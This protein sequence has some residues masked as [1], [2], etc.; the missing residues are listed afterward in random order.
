MHDAT[1]G[2]SSSA[3]EILYCE[4]LRR[5]EVCESL[6]LD[7]F[8]AESP[9]HAEHAAEIR[10]LDDD[11]SNFERFGAA[12]A[13][14]ESGPT[15]GSVAPT[16]D[17]DALP[18]TRGTSAAAEKAFT[19]FLIE[20]ERDPQASFDALCRARPEIASELRA[21][22][23]D[24]RVI[25]ERLSEVSPGLGSLT[26]SLLLESPKGQD[27]AGAARAIFAGFLV[28]LRRGNSKTI[29]ELCE[30]HPEHA[31]D[32][33]ILNEH[34]FQVE[35]LFDDLAAPNSIDTMLFVRNA[36]EALSLT[37]LDESQ[38]ERLIERLLARRRGGRP[39][40]ELGEVGS[41]GMGSI[42]K[43]WDPDLRRNLAMKVAH[44]TPAEIENPD[45]PKT[46]D[47][48]LA[49]F[50]EE[51]QVTSQLDH[52][53]IVPV[54]ELGIDDAGRPYFTMRL[55]RGKDLSAI[56]E[57]VWN[58]QDGWNRTRAVGAMLK[59]CDAVAYAHSKNVVHRDLKPANVM[60]GRFGEVYVMD[61]GLARVQG[62]KSEQDER[63]RD[64]F[65]SMSQAPSLVETDRQAG[66]TGPAAESLLTAH[67]DIVGTPPYMSPE[68]ADGR[69]DDIAE[70]TDVYALGA[71]LYNLLSQ[72]TP[73]IERD[74]R[75][76]A[77]VVWK[78][79]KAGPPVPLE[80]I[81][82]QLPPELV[83]ICEKAMARTVTSRY[84]DTRMLAEDLRA[85]LED[86]VVKAYESGPVAELRKWMKRNRKAASVAGSTLFMTLGGLA[87]SAVL[88]KAGEVQAKQDAE[89]AV[90]EKDDAFAE[91]DA[92]ELAA[93]EAEDQR[94]AALD[95]RKQIEVQIV[96]LGEERDQ[97]KTE[98]RGLGQDVRV[99]NERAEDAMSRTEKVMRLSASRR[100]GQLLAESD[101]LWPPYPWMIEPMERWLEE[102]RSLGIGRAQLV[103][104]RDAMRASA[105]IIEGKELARRRSEL[106]ESERAHAL[107]NEIRMRQ[108]ALT[109]MQADSG[110]LQAILAEREEELAQLGAEID[111]FVAYEFSSAETEWHYDLLVELI[112]DLDDLIEPGV[113]C[114]AAV[115][116]RVR[117]ARELAERRDGEF[118]S[119]WARAIASIASTS[120]CPLYRGLEL[121]PQAGLVPIRRNSGTGLWEFADLLSGELPELDADGQLLLREESAV[122]Y[123][124]LP[125]GSFMMG[126][127]RGAKKPAP[128]R[129]SLAQ[130]REGPVHSVRLEPFFISKYELTKAQ[131]RR[132][133]G[134]HAS[135]EFEPGH[136]FAW[137]AIVTGLHPVDSVTWHQ[138]SAAL[139]E[140]GA[141]LPTEAQWEYAC[142]AGTSTP[143]WSGLDLLS[144]K[145]AANYADA[146]LKVPEG[147]VWDYN[148]TFNDGYVVHAP[149]DTLRANPWGLHHVSGN[150]AE[151]C[152]DGLERYDPLETR[153]PDGARDL[154]MSLERVVRGGSYRSFANQGD[155][156]HSA[157]RT[158]F[159]AEDREATIGVRP[160]RPLDP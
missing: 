91:R 131:W 70:P 82:P 98:I 87:L 100:I 75:P 67:G 6:T 146:R 97:L 61:W 30:R 150:V 136:V 55:V 83:A 11:R 81:D 139:A 48:M 73:Y 94:Q 72:R 58:G 46:V 31:A 104:Q 154:P 43:V 2:D 44:K 117:V 126:A 66:S 10:Q 145:G 147:W 122:V 112:D 86:R 14:D 5:R 17:L 108:V 114:L 40:K 15:G 8:L 47:R 89:V 20:R 133:T 125:G 137:G 120:E 4:F 21:L 102:V 144:L 18:N 111:A 37:Q 85:Y 78:R 62:Q 54:H 135:N 23:A 68:Q 130:P 149:V 106:P 80:S 160:A 128:N 1:L 84:S 96:D 116:A 27:V 123:V 36:R 3:A 119:K 41:G 29:E 64:M 148:S 113:G 156:L 35:E 143:F 92:A 134:R 155:E 50:L 33:R 105:T 138:S 60:V 79:V 158:A 12:V 121:E 141:V 13:F 25:E 7:A 77:L 9:S 39:Y 110:A 63:L 28:A 93:Q 69:L 74:E 151:W 159:V 26:R 24:W 42:L 107:E 32:L 52:P 16:V 152:R 99:A 59:V 103:L 129:D 95:A 127:E 118:A 142:R 49:R 88:F 101:G 22:M 76:S 51:A 157:H 34:W 132:V 109:G 140:F 53:G 38:T 57:Q 153:E 71:M 115:E 124:L 56:F 19:G 65:A 45:G 90:I